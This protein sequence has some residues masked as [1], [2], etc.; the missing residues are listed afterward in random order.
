MDSELIPALIDFIS[1]NLQIY[2]SLGLFVFCVILCLDVLEQ[3]VLQLIRLSPNGDTLALLAVIFTLGD[4]L[5]VLSGQMRAP[6][7]PFFAPCA[8][9]L[10]FHMAGLYC[11]Q[12]ARLTSCR[13]AASVD[14]SYL[15]T[16]DP[17][18]LS[19]QSAFRKSIGTPKGFGSQ[20][21][22]DSRGER[23]FRRLTVVL[24]IL[25]PVLAII[26]TVAHH[27]PKLVFW[28]LSALFIAASTLGAPLTI[29][30][31]LRVLKK[32]LSS[33]G[34]ALAGW[35]GVSEGHSCRAVMLN[36]Y[37]IYPPGTIALVK[38][39]AL[40]D[41]PMDRVLSLTTS[42]IRASGSGLTYVF[43]KALRREKGSTVSVQKITMQENG[44]IGLCQGQRVLV[45]NSDF[46]SRL[47]VA[48]PAGPKDAVFCA[49]GQQAAGMFSLKYN[50]HAAIIPALRGLFAHH[51]SPILITRDFNLDPHRL[52]LSGRL[53][54]DEIAFPDLQ[55]RVELSG[56]GQIHSSTIVAVLCQEGLASFSAALLAA[57]RIY[58]AENF[59]SLFVHLSACIGVFLTATLSSAGAMG[60]MCAWN[61]AFF[62]LL[63]L[64]PI[65]LLSFWT[66]QY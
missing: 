38:S 54:L 45:G 16:H 66:K 53:N 42:V 32:K 5:T 39:Q 43:E 44:L 29:S 34:I 3:G 4:A 59:N 50:M 51:L 64:V 47:G 65:V 1:G 40:N 63:W 6:S 35:P 27:Q 7:L 57:R 52:R 8:L 21:R 31:P 11:I 19:G 20:I 56:P 41:Q 26:T 17:N 25:C 62:L 28:S 60:A 61:L 14:Q 30:L 36:D 15:V 2:L 12:D 55:R 37:D 49:I 13:T 24:M 33:L 10:T 22:A 58:R 48:L 9:V 23:R 46:M 18:V